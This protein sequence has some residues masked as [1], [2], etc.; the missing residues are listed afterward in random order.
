MSKPVNRNTA[1]PFITSKHAG[2]APLGFVLSLSFS[3]M[4][5]L[6]PVIPG[7]NGLFLER[8]QQAD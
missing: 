6:S 7:L 5:L 8:L 4:R 1:T 2:F 3:N